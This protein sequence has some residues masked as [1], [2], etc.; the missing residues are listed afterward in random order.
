MKEGRK[1]T[2]I[3]RK[4]QHT[5]EMWKEDTSSGKLSLQTLSN[6]QEISDEDE[7]QQM[8]LKEGATHSTGGNRE[9]QRE[10]NGSFNTYPIV[11]VR[12]EAARNNVQKQS[13]HQSPLSDYHRLML[14]S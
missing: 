11:N 13:E 5:T 9:V 8:E 7:D 14:H 3:K 2:F 1:K 10:K 12:I 4:L 6:K